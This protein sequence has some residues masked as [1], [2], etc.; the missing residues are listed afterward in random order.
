MID[1]DVVGYKQ[2]LHYG[3]TMPFVF[4]CLFLGEE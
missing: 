4:L 1:P 2:G 3:K